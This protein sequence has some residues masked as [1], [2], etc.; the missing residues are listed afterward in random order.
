MTKKVKKAQAGYKSRS[1]ERSPDGNYKMVVKERET[2]TSKSKTIKEK[3][4]PKGF[5]LGVPKPSKLNPQQ[6]ED[7]M[8]KGP[9]F[10]MSRNGSKTPVKKSVKK[11]IKTSKKKK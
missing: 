1:V 3:R 8:S 9:E 2:P 6:R 5:F 10:Q 7:I 11:S 4:T